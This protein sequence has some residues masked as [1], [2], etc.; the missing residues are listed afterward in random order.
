MQFKICA[1]RGC[2]GTSAASAQLLDCST[3]HKCTNP[4]KPGHQMKQ[5]PEV[6]TKLCLRSQPRSIVVYTAL[7]SRC[8]PNRET[9]SLPWSLTFPEECW[10]TGLGK[11]PR[12]VNADGTTAKVQSNGP[13]PLLYLV[14]WAGAF[15][16]GPGGGSQTDLEP[17]L[18]IPQFPGPPRFAEIRME[19]AR[20]GNCCPSEVVFQPLG[21][22]QTHGMG[23]SYAPLGSSGGVFEGDV[24]DI[25]F[26][27]QAGLTNAIRRVKAYPSLCQALSAITETH[28]LHPAF[29]S[30]S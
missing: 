12:L 19:I 17:L 15:L 4:G 8:L 27:S 9:H 6:T 23:P 26:D 21:P 30:Y 3:V 14:R 5:H 1:F 16:Q 22:V 24:Y 13:V 28:L 18:Q 10:F 11:P 7:D 25:L 29:D 2:Q 20:I